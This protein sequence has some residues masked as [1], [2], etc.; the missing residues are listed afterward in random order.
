MKINIIEEYIEITHKI[1]RVRDFENQLENQADI[2]AEDEEKYTYTNNSND[3]IMRQILK[4]KRQAALNLNEWLKIKEENKIKPEDLE[5]VTESYLTKTWSNE[6]TDILYKDKKYDGIYYLIEHQTKIDYEMA[7]RIAEYRNEI[8]NHYEK[9]SK[10]KNNK[11]Y[12]VANISAIVLYSGDKKWNAKKNLEEIKILNPRLKERI[13]D[14]YKV[15]SMDDY[16]LQNLK[17]KIKQND[18]NILTKIGYIRKVSKIRD[19]DKLIQE[20]KEIKIKKEEVDYIASYIVKRVS[21][22]CGKEKA[23]LMIKNIEKE[24]EEDD[25]DM[26]DEF[27]DRLLYEGKKLGLREGKIQAIIEV[28]INMLK[29]K[30]D[31]QI[32][33]KCT[34]LSETKI[35][36]LEKS[37]QNS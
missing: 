13:K 9:N 37:L 30:C 21:V 16:T 4:D 22:E 17:D 14:D 29:E 1:H 27:V 28:A 34:G 24:Y 20:L 6:E 31:K 35:Q 32:I 36:Q 15:I 10:I 3:K 18:I 7:K 33:K 23:K 26:L 2:L 25:E 11:N 5:E 19:V 12:K 8:Q